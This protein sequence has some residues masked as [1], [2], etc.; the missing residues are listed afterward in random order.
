[1][2]QKNCEGSNIDQIQKE[3]ESFSGTT[4]YYK[5]SPLFPRFVLTDGTLFLADSC[6]CYWLLEL[7]ASYQFDKRIKNHPELIGNTQFWKL[8]VIKN[9]GLLICEWDEG[10]TVLEHSLDYTDFPLQKIKIWVGQTELANEAL[11]SVAYLPSE[12]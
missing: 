7:I 8:E 2:I 10:Q 3:L 9:K 11:V 5:L 1:M 12:Y 6:K 4:G